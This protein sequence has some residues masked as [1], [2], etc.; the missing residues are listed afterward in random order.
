MVMLNVERLTEPLAVENVESPYF[1]P[2]D[3][4]LNADYREDLGEDDEEDELFIQPNVKLSPQKVS[5]MKPECPIVALDSTSRIL[6]YTE[7][8]VVGAIRVA[9]VIRLPDGRREIERYGPY[10]RRFTNR[11]KEELYRTLQLNVFGEAY[12]THAPPLGKIIDRTRNLIE[13]YLQLEIAKKYENSI[14]LFDGSLTSGIIDS[15]KSFN[16]EILDSAHQRGNDIFS[17]AKQTTL[18]MRRS[19]AGIL[20]TV[21]GVYGPCYVSVKK[22]ISQNV[23][24]YK[25]V[26]IYVGK[27]TPMGQPF[28][29][30]V[31]IMTNLSHDRIFSHAC[32]LAGDDGYVEELRLAHVHCILTPIETMEVQAAAMRKY[33]LELKEDEMRKRFFGP[34]GR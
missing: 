6:G 19:E 33:G 20:T 3:A 12:R 26:E 28:R 18:T 13:E 30:D 25:H 27:L 16:K 14:L 10:L 23:D 24:R 5:P 31:P 4:Y 32:S 8:G 2:L 1:R 17:I 9:V 7:D 15:P 11:N 34:Y 21:E 29:I 22:F